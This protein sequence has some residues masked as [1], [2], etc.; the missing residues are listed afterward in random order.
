[1]GVNANASAACVPLADH[2]LG[3]TATLNV[4]QKLQAQGQA[5]PAMV[6]LPGWD[7]GPTT[8]LDTLNNEIAWILDNYVRN[9]RYSSERWLQFDGAPLLVVFDGGG[10]HFGSQVP[11]TEG[12]TVRYMASQ[13]QDNPA[14]ASK[15]EIYVAAM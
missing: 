8:P 11:A 3:T 6:I 10:K 13:L 4:Y 12:F 9:S 15:V 7:N 2:Q 5:C 14:W 1:M